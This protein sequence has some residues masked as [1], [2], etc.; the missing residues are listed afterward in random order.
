M[1]SLRPRCRL[2]LVLGLHRAARP[3][4]GAEPQQ[5]RRGAPRETTWRSLQTF[6]PAYRFWQHIFTIPDGRI[7]FG[8]EEDGRL[9]ATFPSKGDW[10]RDAVWIDP[11]PGRQRART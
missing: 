4:A 3:A 2:A 11:A 10:A 7:A 9:L 1:E 5:P 8:S 6:R